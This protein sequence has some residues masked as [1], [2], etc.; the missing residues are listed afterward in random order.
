MNQRSKEDASRV[1][2][3]LTPALSPLRGEGGTLI[4]L[5]VSAA[6]ASELRGPSGSR[7]S[8]S[9][10]PQTP[11]PLNGERAGVRGENIQKVFK[12]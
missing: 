11:S 1:F 4:S 6:A 8:K 7:I 3:P 9:A 12:N 2:S 5:L 10:P